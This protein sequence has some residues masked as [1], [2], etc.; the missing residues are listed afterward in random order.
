MIPFFNETGD[1]YLHQKRAAENF[2]ETVDPY[3]ATFMAF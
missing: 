2:N 1:R 3:F